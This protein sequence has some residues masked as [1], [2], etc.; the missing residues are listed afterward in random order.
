MESNPGEWIEHNEGIE[1]IVE[2]PTHGLNSHIYIYDPRKL[3][4][5]ISALREPSNTWLYLGIASWTVAGGL[6][7][8]ILGESL[9]VTEGALTGFSASYPLSV[10]AYSMK[11]KL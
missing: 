11:A 4:N 10:A 2:Q 1:Q 9:S 3:L 6:A 7:S 5:Q 8:L